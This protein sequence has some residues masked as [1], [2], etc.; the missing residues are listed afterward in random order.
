MQVFHHKDLTAFLCFE[1][2][3]LVCLCLQFQGPSQNWELVQ[4]MTVLNQ[5][6]RVRFYKI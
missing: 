6:Q 4:N 3:G 5:K 2:I 1:N